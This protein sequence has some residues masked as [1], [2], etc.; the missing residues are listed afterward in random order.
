MNYRFWVDFGFISGLFLG[1]FA[2]FSAFQD[3]LGDSS[4]YI[5]R[6]LTFKEV[7]YIWSTGY[8]RANI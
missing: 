8:N 1:I 3:D 5:W 6:N 7:V 4:E 2:C